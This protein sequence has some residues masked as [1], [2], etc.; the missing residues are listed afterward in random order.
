M[1][2][3]R[4][5]TCLKTL[6][7]VYLPYLKVS[8]LSESWSERICIMKQSTLLAGVCLAAGVGCSVLQVQAAEETGLSETAEALAESEILTETSRPEA[9]K[10]AIAALDLNSPADFQPDLEAS[11]PEPEIIQETTAQTDKS[12]GDLQEAIEPETSA[13]SEADP[14]ADS[15]LTDVPSAADKTQPEA[16]ASAG[17]KNA[18]DLEPGLPVE[19]WSEGKTSYIKN[20][21][22]VTGLVEIGQQTYFFNS[23]GLLQ[24]G[25]HKIDES[26]YCFDLQT[27]AM[28]K[29]LTWLS[30]EYNSKANGGAKTVYYD[31]KTGKMRYG[32]A[33]IDGSFYCFDLSS[34]AMKKGITWLSEQYNSAQ[35][36]GAK[37][38]YYS[39]KD[40]RMRYGQ[41]LIDG[42]YYCFDLNSGAMKKGI[43]WLSEQ[44]NSAQ[45]GGAKTVYYDQK[46][47]QMR[48]GQHLINSKYYCFD[49]DT[50]AM[51]K[52]LTHL[53]EVY[54]SAKNG[55]AKTV[56]YDQKNG[57]MLYGQQKIQGSWY[58]FDLQ[59][60]AMKTG[61]TKLDSV[62][63]GKETVTFFY[64]TDGTKHFG[65]LIQ[66]SVFYNLDAK[67]GALLGKPVN[68]SGKELKLK[69]DLNRTNNCFDVSSLVNSVLRASGLAEISLLCPVTGGAMELGTILDQSEWYQLA[70]SPE[71]VRPGAFFSSDAV[72]TV[73][74]YGRE[75][76]SRKVQVNQDYGH[77]FV[78]TSGEG[79]SGQSVAHDFYECGFQHPN[80]KTVSD[81]SGNIWWKDGNQSAWFTRPMHEENYVIRNSY[82]A[83]WVTPTQK[84]Y[85]LMLALA[86]QNITLAGSQLSG[87]HLIGGSPRGSISFSLV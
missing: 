28:K 26:Y 2:N 42:K 65:N 56:Y 4:I 19:G 23:S 64:K 82:Y 27:G 9:D 61:L 41:Q 7:S 18:P 51:K 6:T 8:R 17:N 47:G 75:K 86:A 73:D 57:Q 35:N 40:G 77:V 84:F 25:Q 32:Q 44:Y 85:E 54:N 49:L 13:S 68:L 67:T 38:V 22:A 15:E 20:G 39:Q 62:Y 71:E 87:K 58:C 3:Y 52:G 66:D 36:G 14:S 70:S 55:G 43:T 60:G 74:S 72:Y 33:Q 69:L 79:K 30:E 45:N 1:G 76:L 59:T 37:T 12:A 10:S 48:Y 81:M 83:G 63:T 50:G 24:K 29:G 34:G 53:S 78:I 80:G 5:F 31:Q 21:K 11:A 16:A 46:N